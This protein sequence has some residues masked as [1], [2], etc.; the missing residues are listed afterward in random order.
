M[1]CCSR[2]LTERIWEGPKSGR[3]CQ[4]IKCLVNLPESFALESISAERYTCHQEGPWVRTNMDQ[5]RWLARDNQALTPLPWTQDCE[6]RGRAVLLGSLTRCSPPGHPFPINSLALSSPVSPRTIHF[7]VLDKSPL[8]DSGR[9]PPSCNIR[10]QFLSTAAVCFPILY[11]PF[12]WWQSP[13]SSEISP[14]TKR[15]SLFQ[16]SRYKKILYANGWFTLMFGRN[17]HNSVKQLSFN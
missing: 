7:W 6:P 8:S 2:K 16:Y 9:G 5:A 17:Q 15:A 1:W 4:P 13:T 3:R 12:S 14:D 10:T 11:G